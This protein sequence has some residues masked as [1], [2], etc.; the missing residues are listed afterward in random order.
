M[1]EGTYDD[2]DL[3]KCYAGV[4]FPDFVKPLANGRFGSKVM[5]Q[6]TSAPKFLESH[7]L[8]TYTTYDIYELVIWINLETK[9]GKVKTV[10]VHPN[11]ELPIELK[12][13]SPT[14]ARQRE[15]EKKRLETDAAENNAS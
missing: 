4:I 7:P 14:E 13:I 10:P 1:T 11:G 5:A 9:D 3:H 8:H 6:G 2:A 12:I 15:A